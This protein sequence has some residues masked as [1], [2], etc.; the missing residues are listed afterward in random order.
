M[1]DKGINVLE[2]YDFTVFRTYRGRGALVLVTD[3]GIRLLKEYSG[4]PKRL[5]KQERLL[6]KIEEN[7]LVRVDS[8]VPNKDGELL[9]EDKDRVP[10]YVRNWFEGM[11]CDVKSPEQIRL[12]AQ[13]L[14]MLHRIMKMPEFIEEGFTIDT[15]S[16]Q[17]SRRT[18]ELNKTRTFIRERSQKS[19][20]ENFYLSCFSHFYDQAVAAG[21]KSRMQSELDL[22][23]SVK[24]DGA[25]CHGD[26]T[27]HNL[28]YAAGD[29][30]VINF[31]HFTNDTQIRDLG[32][33]CR[34]VCEKN[35]WNIEI[36]RILLDG[37]T[38]VR[39]LSDAEWENLSLRLFYPEKFWKITNHYYNSRKAF[40]PEKSTE[41]LSALI[42]SENRKLLFLKEL[43][44]IS[45]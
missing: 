35:N 43:F 38:K 40:H 31:E 29:M 17:F 2:K 8:L 27:Y 30:A 33:F 44:Q 20:F 24:R 18:R 6:K 14:A 3:Q 28:I 21:E 9:S 37:Y 11:E 39:M 25:V 26:Y 45:L 16:H 19:E 4:N 7:S 34:K 36:G 10:Y 42:E 1:N 15:L 32:N 5:K 22:Y 13:K 23:E 41:K 12:S